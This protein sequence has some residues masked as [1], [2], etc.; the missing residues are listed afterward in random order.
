MLAAD[1]AMSTLVS[2]GSAIPSS[3]PFA[4]LQGVGDPVY[5]LGLV[6]PGTA[7][8]SYRVMTRWTEVLMAAAPIFLLL[9]VPKAPVL[10]GL[11]LLFILLLL[12]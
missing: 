10:T 1:P 6:L 8:V 5:T 9:P 2:P 7:V 12:E 11:P 3:A 4:V